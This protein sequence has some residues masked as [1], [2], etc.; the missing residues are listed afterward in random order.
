LEI[1]S[2]VVAK[3]FF[4]GN[5]FLEYKELIHE[6]VLLKLKTDVEIVEEVVAFSF[7]SEMNWIAVNLDAFGK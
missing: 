1:P 3:L 7:I 4:L 6:V 5:Q 2:S